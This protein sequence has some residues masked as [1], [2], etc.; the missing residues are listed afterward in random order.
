MDTTTIARTREDTS[1][2]VKR[3]PLPQK[4]NTYILRE[5]AA[6]FFC[7]NSTPVSD[8]RP[9]IHQIIL[10]RDLLHLLIR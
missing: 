2:C 5:L 4:R 1:S 8:L 6:A 7:H 10:F 9:Q 3:F